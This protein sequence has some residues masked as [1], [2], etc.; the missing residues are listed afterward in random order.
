MAS[1]R[2]DCVERGGGDGEGRNKGGYC[3][4]SWVNILIGCWVVFGRN[5]PV[6]RGSGVLFIV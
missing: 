5:K 3:C 2:V 4:L 1:K 6:L